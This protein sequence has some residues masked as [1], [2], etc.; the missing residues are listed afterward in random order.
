MRT[1]T[2]VLT[3]RF[4]GDCSPAPGPSSAPGLPPPEREGAGRSPA[5]SGCLC[6][7]RPFA[8]RL[9]AMRVLRT[10]GRSARAR[11]R[12]DPPLGTALCI[13]LRHWAW[14]HR[15]PG[16]PGPYA[17]STRRSP[18]FR[19]QLPVL[20]LPSA[21]GHVAGQQALLPINAPE[22]CGSESFGTRP[23]PSQRGSEVAEE[24]PSG[25]FT[26]AEHDAP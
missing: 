22:G 5:L 8:P 13:A 7:C 24:N 21:E 12:A 25:R 20:Q 15:G 26:R 1:T 3:V 17:R 11:E 4:S 16:C 23:A 10:K 9:S 19:A 18:S 14:H 2:S 6:E